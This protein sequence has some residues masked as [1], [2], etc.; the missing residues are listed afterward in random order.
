MTVERRENGQT[1]RFKLTPEPCTD[2]PFKGYVRLN[3][4]SAAA[5]RD[6]NLVMNNLLHHFNVENLR[7]AFRQLSEKKA[8]GI[9]QITKAKYRGNLEENLQKLANEIQRGGFRPRPSRE[10][11]I[12]KPQG[13][14][15]S[16]AI[17]C[18][19]DKLVQLLTGKILEALF[20][21]LFT[22]RSYGFRPKRGT[23]DALTR[24]YKVTRERYD[25]AV[26]V[27]MDIEKFFDAIDHDLLMSFVEKRISDAHVLRLIRR[28]LRNSILHENGE[29][30]RSDRGA[31][32][33]APLSPILANIYLHYVLDLWFEENWEDKGEM[34]RYADDA[35][36][37]FTNEETARSFQSS[38][39]ERLENFG[40][41]RM[42][43]GKSGLFSFN[44][45][46]AENQLG[47]VGFSL[48]WGK[49]GARRKTLKI[50]TAP[51]KLG[52]CI[53]AFTDWIKN[54]RN[55]L[56]TKKIWE[57][58]ASKLTGH[59]LYYGLRFNR[60]KLYHFY[61]SAIG[62]LFKWLNRRSQKHSFDAEKFRRKLKYNPLPLP[63]I[64]AALK[65]ITS[66]IDSTL[67]RKTTSRMRKSRTSGSYR[68]RGWQ[69]LL[70]T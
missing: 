7:Q 64:E 9:D 14:H 26:A 47:F 2:G 13:G 57:E 33:G 52:K 23:H 27:E 43:E 51:K 53:E 55:R 34:V 12:P 70:F 29:L 61:Y 49:S 5:K 3:W 15:R 35:V 63:P 56:S 24:L 48:Y 69:Q 60:T 10:V 8:V 21:P 1:N 17:G 37:I 40:R 59:Y 50:K 25:S 6:E 4:I 19:E 31:P 45:K 36:F 30:K 67:K 22:E 38:L 39:K 20:E 54:N 18:F 46:K 68:S 58:A 44:T 66:S 65:D 16:L 41:L 32:Q 11:L 42:N 28:M 62:V